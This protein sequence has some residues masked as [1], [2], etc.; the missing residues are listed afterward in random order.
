MHPF[1]AEQ[2]VA[3]HQ[4]RAHEAARHS[5]LVKSARAAQPH[6]GPSQVRQGLRLAAAAVGISVALVAFEGASPRSN[7]DPSRPPTTTEPVTLVGPSEG[8][9]AGWTTHRT[10]N[11]KG[12]VVETLVTTHLADR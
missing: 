12:D 10:V 7:A 2:L 5:R 1:V 11:E 3:G 9:A 8:H 4:A 6:R